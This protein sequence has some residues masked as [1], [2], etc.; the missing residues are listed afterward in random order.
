MHQI[1][2]INH[3]ETSILEGNGIAVKLVGEQANVVDAVDA[4]ATGIER[5][6]LPLEYQGTDYLP[7]KKP[8]GLS[9]YSLPPRATTRACPWADHGY[10]PELAAQRFR[11]G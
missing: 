10:V 4:V 6:A 9:W 3:C 11:A 5:C 8:A 1:A 2:K 7:C